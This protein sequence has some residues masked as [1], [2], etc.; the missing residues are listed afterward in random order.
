[1][2]QKTSKRGRTEDTKGQKSKEFCWREKRETGVDVDA[3]PE[4]QFE[5]YSL[6]L[7]IYI[8]EIDSKNEFF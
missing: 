3:N 8:G 1:M 2:N 6:A 4:A 7:G 5:L